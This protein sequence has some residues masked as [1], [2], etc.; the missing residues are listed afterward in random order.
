LH[1]RKIAVIGLGYAGLP[2][3]VAFARTGASVIGF[4][5]DADRIV[6]LRSGTDPSHELEATDLKRHN[7]QFSSTPADLAQADFYVIAVPTPID[8]KRRPDLSW[9]LRASETIGR[10]LARG[11]IVVYESTVYPG[12]TEEDCIPVLERASNLR[13]GVDFTVGYSPERINVG[14]RQHRFET[15]EKVI[16]GQDTRTLDIVAAVYGSVVPHLHRAPSI[17]VAEAAKVLEN[18]QRDVNIALMNEFSAICHALDIDTMDVIAAA[19]T[20][21]NFCQFTPGLVSGHC[22]G[23]AS[24]YLT[25]RAAEAGFRPE[26]IVSGRQTN[27][28]VGRRIGRE[29]IRRLRENQ[30]SPQRV[31]ILGLAF[32]EN[33]S[34]IR[35]SKV[36]DIVG[37]LQSAGVTVQVNDPMARPEDVMREYGITLTKDADLS[38]SDA[39][40]LAVPHAA[41]VDA[42]WPMISRLLKNGRG[43]VMDV[44]AK[45][46]RAGKPHGIDLW[47]L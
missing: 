19:R 20:K 6:A 38:P 23:G 16:A 40:I 37:E 5:I 46:C 47:R 9:L 33:V 3:A 7:L 30:D 44:K 22:I 11:N 41:Y 26:M 43:L 45:L 35:N 25:Y 32:K 17:R 29:C 14:D 36:V 2:A 4:D 31:T 24:Y 39:V 28:S 34:D 15:I 8:A 13:A 18:A 42:G 10:V 1:D 27:E 12:A 21:W